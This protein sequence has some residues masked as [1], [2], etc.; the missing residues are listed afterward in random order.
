MRVCRPEEMGI[1]TTPGTMIA[2]WVRGLTASMIPDLALGARPSTL[3]HLWRDMSQSGLCERRS[4]GA[5]L[6]ERGSKKRCCNGNA[7]DKRRP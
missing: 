4:E 3:A 7:R 1:V 6:V 2:I 5:P